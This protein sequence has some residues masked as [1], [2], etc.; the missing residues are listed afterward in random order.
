MKI[1]SFCGGKRAICTVKAGKSDFSGQTCHQSEAKNK[2]ANVCFVFLALFVVSY[3]LQS[4]MIRLTVCQ[5][6]ANES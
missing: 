2:M 4:A 1:S 3:N 5:W 6:S